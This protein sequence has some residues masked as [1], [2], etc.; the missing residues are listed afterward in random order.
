MKERD[1][2]VA[3]LIPCYN[4]APTIQLVVRHFKAELPG[5]EVYVYDNNSTDETSH[6]A[7]EAGATVRHASLQGKGN[8]VR[9]MFADIDAEYYILVDGDATYDASSVPRMLETAV[10]ANLDMV[11]GSRED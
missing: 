5:A 6:L 8:V 7:R 11:V 9:Q 4:E 3:V 1:L 2:R 10:T